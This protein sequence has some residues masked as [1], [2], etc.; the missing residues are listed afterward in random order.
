[1]RPSAD[2]L[3]RMR[4]FIEATWRLNRVAVSRDATRTCEIIAEEIGGEILRVPSG[5]ECLTW[6]IPPRWEVEEAYVETLDGE[7]ILDYRD[8]PLHV[9]LY[10]APFEGVLDL[11]ELRPHLHSSEAMPDDIPFHNRWTY[12]PGD[13]TEWGFCLPHNRYRR[14]RPARYRVVLRATFQPGEMAVHHASARGQHENTLFVFAHTCHPGQVNDGVA[15]I[16]VAMELFRG[17]VRRREGLR[18]SYRV[19]FGPEYHAAAGYLTHAKGI[20]HLRYGISLDM[21]ANYQPL[22]FSRSFLG[23][24]YL[25]KATRNVMAHH[26]PGSFERAY[27]DLW[28]NDEMFYDGPDFRI[29]VVT[30]GRDKFPAYHHSS[31]DLEHCN[32]AQ[33]EDTLS[34]LQRLVQVFE[35]DRRLRRRYRGPLYLSRYG[36]YIDPK[37]ER[38]GARALQQ[39][40]IL[41]DGERS[42]LEIADALKIDFEF[43]RRFGDELLQLGLAEEDP[44]FAP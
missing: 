32:W 2:A 40:Q 41:M 13:F 36:L 22:G 43:V 3:A 20:E 1:M 15:C 39:I 33:M 4:R 24:T 29:P 14:L 12:R 31:D 25:D 34:V 18:Y 7:R 42:Y 26:V 27:R 16:A 28:G 11:E 38:A 44:T 8:N 21:M 10:S 37:K 6:I 9:C 5:S 23:D 30:I 17:L 35:T 19:I